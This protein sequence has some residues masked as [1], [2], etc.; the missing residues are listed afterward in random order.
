[1]ILVTGKNS[2]LG[3]CLKKIIP[4]AIFTSSSELDITN[5]IA[6]NSFIIKNNIDI[7][8]NCDEYS[9][10]D[11]AERQIAL[12]ELSNRFGPMN[13]AKTGVKVIHIS[14]DYVFG[15]DSKIPYR[16]DNNT[17][18]LTSYGKT[19]LAGELALLELAKK[20]IIIRTSWL[21]SEYGDNFVTNMLRL[22][23]DKIRVSAI[24]DQ[25]SSPTYAMDLATIIVNILPQLDKNQSG[26]YHYSNA[27]VCS[28]FDLA[29]TT[30]VMANLPCKVIPISSDISKRPSYSV[31]D[32]NKIRDT[33]GINIPNWRHSLAEMLKS[34][35]EIIS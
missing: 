1:M 33:F 18:P 35:Y 24:C 26:V 6:L 29:T 28:L 5:Y 21:Y 3:L 30:M 27:G 11:K 15:G 31:L 25:L 17:S 32:T 34:T 19:K 9:D 14:T 8:I 7:V 20:A 23:Q 16:E 2:Q 12:S 13:I 4:T 22:G 10:I